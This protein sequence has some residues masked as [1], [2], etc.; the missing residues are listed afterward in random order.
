M[1]AIGIFVFLSVLL[2]LGKLLRTLIPFFQL[3]YLPSSVIAGIVGLLLVNLFPA[4]VPASWLASIKQMPGFLINVV[5]A[6]L[7]L[8]ASIPALR[9]VWQLALPQF[10]YGQLQAWGQYVLGIGLA[11]LLLVP[12]FGVSSGFGN[13]LEIGFE[14]GHGTVGGMAASMTEFNWSEGI[15]LGYT[16]ATI[17]MISG[18]VLGIALINWARRRGHLTLSSTG[19]A[20]DKSKLI[21]IYPKGERPA[22]G[23]QTVISDSIDSLA[24]HLALLGLAILIGW[25]MLKGL[26]EMEMGLRSLFSWEASFVFFKAFPLFP[27]CMIG[28]LLL[29]KIAEATGWGKLIDHG[30]MQRLTGASLDF[31][32]VAAVCTI[33]LDVITSNWA[34]LLILIVAG[35]AWSVTMLLYVAPR[36]FKQDWFERGIAEFGQSMGVTATGLLL[37]RTVDPENKTS[38]PAAFGYKQLLHEPIMGGGLWTALALPLVF[39]QGALTVLVI[40]LVFFAFWTLIAWRI[41]RVKQS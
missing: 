22:A 6:G 41:A 24:W 31:L 15:A 8:G 35:I 5:F 28:G 23:R 20:V 34:A 2:V 21:G 13:L 19:S 12:V 9:K 39:T 14:G 16:V 38:A 29:Q 40:S 18:V 10:C 27:L 3:L 32:V 25:L 33:Q 1:E 26:T 7:F 37:L 30:Q 4:A 36:L 17:G 11:L